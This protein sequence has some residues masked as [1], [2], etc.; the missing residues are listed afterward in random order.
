[1]RGRRSF[2]FWHRMPFIG[3]LLITTCLAL[4]VAGGAM[5]SFSVSQDAA[6]ARTDI[7]D[8]LVNELR[9]VPAVLAEN[10][11]V[12]DFS[13]LQQS[14]DRI[15]INPR[16]HMVRFRDSSGV[17]MIS[18]D[19]PIPRQAPD[20]FQQLL[21]VEDLSGS[22]PVIIGGRVYGDLS[23]TLTA[24][25]LVNRSWTRLIH[26]LTILLAAI[27]A[28]FLGIW[29]V[30]RSGLSPLKQLE[31]AAHAMTAGDLG[32]RLAVVGSP[33]LRHVI[34]AFNGMAEATQAAHQRLHFTNAELLRLTEVMAH[35][36]QE[37]ARRL[38]TFARRLKILL[39]MQMLS[40][41]ANVALTFIEQQ[42]NRLRALIRDIQLYLAVDQPLGAVYALPLGKVVEKVVASRADDLA[43]M[44][45]TVIVDAAMPSILLDQWRLIN[46]VEILLDNAMR[47]C[48]PDVPLRLHVS[49]KI[50]GPMVELRFADN[51]QG[52]AR[53][54]HERVFKVFERLNPMAGDDSTGVGL[55]IV[56]RIVEHGNGKVWVEDTL[57]GGATLVLEWPAATDQ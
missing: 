8:E 10:V 29:L 21:G 27:G 57:G 13:A 23:V 34:I 19:A 52:I 38:V 25:A 15:V 7:Q 41:E 5:V 54:Y 51:G 35:H 26:H 48:R 45:A 4:V 33:E 31:D 24:Q 3:R 9:V 32:G 47:Y 20:W 42:A 50:M 11:V 17:D 6:D 18:R 37:P 53:E 49:A 1:M 30:L 14:L 36:F 22:A 2:A 12:G 46:M 40:K 39:G 56:R 16:I 28:D 44:G 43:A 55:A